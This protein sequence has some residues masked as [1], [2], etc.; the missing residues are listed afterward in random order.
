MSAHRPRLVVACALFAVIL[1]IIFTTNP[2]RLHIRPSFTQVNEHDRTEPAAKGDGDAATASWLQSLELGASVEY[3]RICLAAKQKSGMTRQS[4]VRLSRSLHID[5]ASHSMR[6]HV[7]AGEIPTCATRLDVPV[8]SFTSASTP[9]RTLLLGMATRLE[10]VRPALDDAAR[11]LSNSGVNL[12]VLVTDVLNLN[13]VRAE[14]D[15]V[16]R[17]ARSLHIELNLIAYA[18]QETEDGR[19]NFGL[20]EPLLAEAN[21]R[22]GTEWVGI[23][24]DDTFF[25]SLQE[26]ERRLAAFNATEPAYLGALSEGWSRVSQEGL[27]GWGGAGFFLS[28]PLLSLLA[29]HA[30]ECRREHQTIF[31]DILWRDCIF[32]ATSPTVSLTPLDGLNQLD[33]WRDVSGWYESDHPSLLT[34]H[35]W[36]SWHFHPVPLAHTV[37]DVA[38][39]SSFLQRYTFG[40][41]NLVLTNGYSLVQYPQGLPDLELTE[42]TMVE[43][44]G[45]DRPPNWLEFHASLGRTRPAL[46]PEVEKVSWRFEHAVLDGD[47]VRQFYVRRAL[48]PPDRVQHVIEIDWLKA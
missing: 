8:P 19:R 9:A 21:R 37:V 7:Q 11:W 41:D 3:T 12:L 13:D 18:G 27:K 33:M 34:L 47:I 35:H 31:G 10:R 29:L 46:I 48:E 2:N 43:D 5:Q 28:I 38:G 16:R 44:V 4:I 32:S 24:D 40:A 25:V 17:A 42:L 14:V 23:I 30:E 6:P 20:V 26:M 39:P 1:F 45:L 22:A 36:K 15:E